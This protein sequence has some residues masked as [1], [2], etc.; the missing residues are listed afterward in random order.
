M[1]SRIV[2]TEQGEAIR[3]SPLF[4]GERADVFGRGPR[5]RRSED[6]H[7][8]LIVHERCR[9]FVDAL[10]VSES[11]FVLT[12]RAC[13]LRVYAPASIETFEQLR[14]HFGPLNTHS[15]EGDQS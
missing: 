7:S 14:D 6:S 5:I 4:G 15:A 12:C 9:G 13:G 11:R 8:T 10:D 2:L 3:P 1:I